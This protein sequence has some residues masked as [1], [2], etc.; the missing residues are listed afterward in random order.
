MPFPSASADR[1]AFRI[2]VRGRSGDQRNPESESV[3][4]SD[5]APELYSGYRR[6]RVGSEKTA[7]TPG[8]RLLCGTAGG[9][10]VGHCEKVLHHIRTYQ[11]HEPSDRRNPGRTETTDRE[12]S[13]PSYGLLRKEQQNILLTILYF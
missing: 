11:K 6:E 2:H 5:H 13:G 9:Y 1:A 3:C 4:C 12:I 10:P 8:D 7:G